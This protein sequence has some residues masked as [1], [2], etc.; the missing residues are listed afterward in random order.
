M[1]DQTS[2]QRWNSLSK[3]RALVHLAVQL[4]LLGLLALVSGYRIPDF[5]D[6]NWL[7]VMFLTPSGIVT[8]HLD[9][10]SVIRSFYGEISSGQV[11]LN[12][13]QIAFMT[14]IYVGL[15]ANLFWLLK[16]NRSLEA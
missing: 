13:S 2:K 8:N 5:N 9:S 4:L 7:T 11:T 16:S 3:K 6:S 14:L 15:V 1:P 10:E 12:F